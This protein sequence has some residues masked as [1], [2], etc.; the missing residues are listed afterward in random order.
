METSSDYERYLFANVRI[1]PFQ[2]LVRIQVASFQAHNIADENNF[3]QSKK[4]AEKRIMT[5]KNRKL[6]KTPRMPRKIHF[7]SKT[8]FGKECNPSSKLEMQLIQ[9]EWSKAGVCL[10]NVGS[11]HYQLIFMKRLDENLVT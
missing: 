6:R 4:P 3:I 10:P 9:I 1:Y 8:I 5:E 7:T 2:F 11:R